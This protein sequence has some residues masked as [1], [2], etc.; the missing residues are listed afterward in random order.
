MI[1]S[2]IM[3]LLR[4][5]CTVNNNAHF[6]MHSSATHQEIPIGP[7]SLQLPPIPKELAFPPEV[8]N[9][10]LI[11]AGDDRH[12]S[13]RSRHSHYHSDSHRSRSRDSH[14]SRDYD[15]HRSSHHSGSR[16]DSHRD[17]H[18]ERSRANETLSVS[19]AAVDQGSKGQS[20]V[21]YETFQKGSSNSTTSGS[22]SVPTL[23]TV[24]VCAV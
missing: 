11:M 2:R 7:L 15:R 9:Q 1:D 22:S 16:H 3:L 14:R 21:R 18:R 4:L 6:I 20:S 24:N 23:P 8:A 13:S 5:E 12:H 17:S 10:Q 19:R